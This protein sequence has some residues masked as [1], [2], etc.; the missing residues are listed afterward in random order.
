MAVLYPAALGKSED[1][2][3]FSPDKTPDA[4]RQNAGLDAGNKGYVTVRD[5]VAAVERSTGGGGGARPPGGTTGPAQAPPTDPR[6]AQIEARIKKGQALVLEV[7]NQPGM[8]AQAALLNQ[9]VND[10]QKERDRLDAPRQ[11]FLKRQAIQG[12][13]L[14]EKEREGLQ[15]AQLEADTR[16]A[17]TTEIDAINRGLPR[18]QQLPYGTTHKQIRERGLIGA[19]AISEPI[20]EKLLTTTTAIQ[21]FEE[22]NNAVT[23]LPT[24]PLTQYVEQFKERW[25]IDISD[26]KVAQR[27]IL[28]GATNQLL[29]ARN[30]AAISPSE[31]QRLLA[32]LPNEAN[33]PKVFKA[34]LANTVRQFKNIYKTQYTVSAQVWGGH[35]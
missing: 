1:T 26:E 22:L 17:S 25:G 23:Q 14:E 6:L 10:L 32:E 35:P 8:E 31:H 4:Y 21:Q 34:R 12:Q 27:A 2:V 18:D 33:D 15:R 16:P 11:E 28:A 13:I 9:Q 7:A 20:R 3:L 24:G 19:E 29:S 5:A 30:G